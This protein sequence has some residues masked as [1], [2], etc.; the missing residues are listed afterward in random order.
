MGHSRLGALFDRARGSESGSQQRAPADETA[1]ASAVR[2]TR[3]LRWLAGL[4]I[5]VVVVPL[6]VG[7]F[8][9]WPTRANGDPWN[10]L[11]AAER[12]NAGHPL[13]G[14]T[15]GDRPVELHP[16]Y[17]SVPLLSPPFIAV[18]WRPLAFLGDAAMVIWWIG[19]IAA[20]AIYVAWLLRRLDNPWSIIALVALS[21]AIA[22]G[23]LSG[24]AIAYLLPMLAHR[25]PAPVAVAAGVRLTPALLAP[26][27]G[28][29]ATIGY[30]L[31]VGIISLLGAGLQNHLD[32][33][34]AVTTSAP[35]P[36]SI[37]GLTGLPPLAVAL[38][39]L[40]IAVLGWRWAV[41][42]MTLASPTTYLYTFG[43]LSLLLVP[44]GDRRLGPDPVPRW[45][46]LVT[47]SLDRG[48]R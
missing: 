8:E 39:G 19:G 48:R 24:N 7:T 15:P 3:R 45:R 27:S 14:L 20:T 28:L 17:W 38:A 31:V 26:S 5:L 1:R 32:W 2:A 4:S 47:M 42:A 12:L 44:K 37:S 21:P 29:R 43:L 23:A 18:L 11:A 9:T 6:V 25:H 36:L 34:Q 30:G 13:Y 46:R 40:A 35:T 10:Y 16:P 22:Y 33:L 41:I